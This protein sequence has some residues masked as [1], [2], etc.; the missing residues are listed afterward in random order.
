VT[1]LQSDPRATGDVVEGYRR[2]SEGL[3]AGLRELGLEA[4]QASAKKPGGE[5]TAVCFETPSGYEITVGGR[6]LVGSAQ[7]RAR[8]GVLQH[9]T[10][11]LHGDIARIVD[12]LV[13]SDAEREA[14]RRA[15]RSRAT[16]LEQSLGFILPFSEA[17]HALA[18]G[19][20]LAL[21]LTFIAGEPTARERALAAELRHSRYAA[22]EWNRRT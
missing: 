17:A 14:Q 7:W 6:K 1:L 4:V 8:G 15:V 19:F 5:V 2:L 16:T 9:G 10:L 12:C 11:P 21:D 13:F 3:L 22:W 20:A 18:A